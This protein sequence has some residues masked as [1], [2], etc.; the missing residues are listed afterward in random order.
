MRPM[1]VKKAMIL[2]HSMDSFEVNVNSMPI[3]MSDESDCDAADDD[4]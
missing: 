4:E 3:D 1:K 2:F